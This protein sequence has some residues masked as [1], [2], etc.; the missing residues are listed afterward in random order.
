MS[1]CK[2]KSYVNNI[3]MVGIMACIIYIYKI[4]MNINI[5]GRDCRAVM[6]HI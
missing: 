6:F 1:V 3:I 2:I 4:I 5:Y